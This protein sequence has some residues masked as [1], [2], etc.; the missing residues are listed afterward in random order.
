MVTQREIADQVFDDK[1]LGLP[2]FDLFEHNSQR[3]RE[4]NRH[5]C[6]NPEHTRSRR[7]KRRLVHWLGAAEETLYT[8][9]RRPKCER[10]ARGQRE[11]DQDRKDSHG[12]WLLKFPLLFDCAAQR[13]C[14]GTLRRNVSPC[15]TP[16]NQHS[17]AEENLSRKQGQPSF[18]VIA[19]F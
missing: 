15:S 1:P 13:Y 17:F 10:V 7:P 9:T 2:R 19:D 4:G 16:W 5:V 6:T 12:C 18:E 8:A 11:H 3:R 14:R